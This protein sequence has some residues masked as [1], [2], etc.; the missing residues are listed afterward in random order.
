MPCSH[1]ISRGNYNIKSSSIPFHIQSSSF[2]QNAHSSFAS[3]HF[4]S[5]HSI[6]STYR[7]SFPQT[8]P[9]LSIHLYWSMFL[10][11][12]S[13]VHKSPFVPAHTPHPYTL[14]SSHSPT[15]TNSY[16]SHLNGVTSSSSPVT[17]YLTSPQGYPYPH[18]YL[19]TTITKAYL[20]HSHPSPSPAHTSIHPFATHQVGF[21]HQLADEWLDCVHHLGNVW[22][23]GHGAGR[24]YK[25]LGTCH[26]ILCSLRGLPLLPR[27]ITIMAGWRRSWVQLDGAATAVIILIA[28]SVK[29]HC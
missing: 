21:L 28:S 10:E 26:R 7:L 17:Y 3:L 20:T 24:E 25:H 19:S 11:T 13:R 1:W 14:W 22:V 15:V 16:Y 12:G 4:E 5:L 6:L 9:N 23:D 2:Y 27:R 29:C 18:P 8:S